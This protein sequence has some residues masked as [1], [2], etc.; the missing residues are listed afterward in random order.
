MKPIFECYQEI[1]P[2]LS[3][4]EES[5]KRPL[6]MHFRVNLLKIETEKLIEILREKGVYLKSTGDGSG[7]IFEASGLKSLGNLIEY[8]TGYIHPQALT[9]CLAPFALAPEPET[10]VLDM[11]ASPGGKTSQLAQIMNNSG[12]VVANEPYPN[13]HIPL[14]H[15]LSRLGVL[16]TVFTAY[17]AQEFPLKQRFDYVL[18]DVPCSGEGRIR[19]IREG[20]TGNP[21]GRHIKRSRLLAL[22]KR[23]IIRG[24]DLLKDKGEMLYSTCTYDPDENEAVVHFLLENRDAELL[25]INLGFYSEPGLTRWRDKTY[26]KQLEHAVRFYP[27]R[28][29][30]IGFFMARIGRGRG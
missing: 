10:S 12:L 5:L 14:A 28:V 19:H 24:Y 30:S 29:D 1:I 27:H 26:D 4:L 6:P 13:R 2:D 7:T 18:A 17:Q 15:T 8:F 3:L 16:N 9:S 23:I 20:Y 11:C 21:N 25:P 22:Q